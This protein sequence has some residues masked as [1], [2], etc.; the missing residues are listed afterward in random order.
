MKAEAFPSSN[1]GALLFNC[2][3]NKTLRHK[4]LF[5]TF[6]GHKGTCFSVIVQQLFS[7]LQLK[8][9]SIKTAHGRPWTKDLREIS[10]ILQDSEVVGS[11]PREEARFVR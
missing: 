8:A 2:R 7:Y 4:P 11:V 9:T 3:L 6:T 1:Q 10:L 5:S